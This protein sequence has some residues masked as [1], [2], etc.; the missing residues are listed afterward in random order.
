[1][2]RLASSIALPAIAAL[3]KLHPELQ[4]ELSVF[5][6]AEMNERLASRNFDLGLAVMPINNKKVEVVRVGTS[7]VRVLVARNHPLASVRE[8][9][10]SQIVSEPV[11]ALPDS[12]TDRNNMDALYSNHAATPNI[13]MIVPTVEIAATLTAAGVGISFADELSLSTFKHLDLSIIAIHP[14]WHL[15]FGIFKP[16]HQPPP[17]PVREL[18]TVLEQRLEQIG[19]IP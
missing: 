18:I 8:M 19:Y 10:F 3:Q 5:Y 9:A 15:S 14:T 12:T 4:C 16:A 6:R 13:R 7:P 11:I 1:M 17:P 2:A